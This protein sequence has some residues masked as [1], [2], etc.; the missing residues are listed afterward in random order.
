M[1][2][3]EQ[4]LQQLRDRWLEAKKIGDAKSMKIIE[5]RAK[6]LKMKSKETDTVEIAEDVFGVK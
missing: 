6:L 2:S 1:E 5:I 4:Q 3:I